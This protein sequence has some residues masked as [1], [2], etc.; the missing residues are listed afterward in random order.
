LTADLEFR[1]W[2]GY[3]KVKSKKTG[4]K[5]RRDGKNRTE[6]DYDFMKTK[7]NQTG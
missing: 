4:G 5:V 2:E 6:M 3:R 1:G 7:K